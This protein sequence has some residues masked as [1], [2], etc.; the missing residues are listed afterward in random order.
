MEGYVAIAKGIGSADA[1]AVVLAVAALRDDPETV[2]DALRA[3]HLI[4]FV[5][6]AIDESRG[7]DGVPAELLA[8]LA[9]RR[10]IQ[11]ASVEALCELFDEVRRELAQAGVPAVL[12]KGLSLAERL[13]GGLD[14]RPQFDVDVLVPR[15]LFKAAIRALRRRGFASAAYDLHSRTV[16]RGEGKVDVHHALRWAPAYRLD[17]RALWN[18]ARDVTIAGRPV[19]T[20]SD[21]HTLVMLILNAFEDVGQGMVR[22]KQLLDLWLLVRNV[23]GT[24]DWQRFLERRARENL[25]A[26]SVNVLALVLDLFEARGLAPHLDAALRPHA[27]RL[28]HANRDA[29]LALLA[30]PRKAPESFEWFASVYPGS[31]GRYLVWFWLGGFPAN[32]RNLGSPWVTKALRLAVA[33]ATHR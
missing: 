5:R 29:A 25:L 11:R 3:H 12:M 22:L 31:V 18:D 17:E 10:P 7:A 9:S 26:V 14:R 4:G 1:N 24:L 21:E 2:A 27:G 15:R 32:L 19:R 16:V 8:A 33:P 30:A 6:R 20:L 23:D 13:Y 28:R